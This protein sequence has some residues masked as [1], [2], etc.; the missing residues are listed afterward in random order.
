MWML[1]VVE[2]TTWASISPQLPGPFCPLWNACGKKSMHEL[3]LQQLMW[4]KGKSV[5]VL[6]QLQN[7]TLK[8]CF[9]GKSYGDVLG[10]KKR[11]KNI[12]NS[13]GSQSPLQKSIALCSGKASGKVRGT[14]KDKNY[15]F[16]SW[17]HCSLQLF[18]QR[19]LPLWQWQWD[20]PMLSC[21]EVGACP[22]RYGQQGWTPLPQPPGFLPLFGE[23]KTHSPAL[24]CVPHGLPPCPMLHKDPWPPCPLG[25][26]SCAVQECVGATKSKSSQQRGCQQMVLQPMLPH[27]PVCEGYYWKLSS[28]LE[29]QLAPSV[30]WFGVWSYLHHMI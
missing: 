26:I 16:E 19:C 22:S 30:P 7:Q 3:S 9:T 12:F 27:S 25:A 1:Q 10:K 29:E 28:C 14:Q 18:L 20:S 5:N 21:K 11:Q 15:V 6:W 24:S 8:G 13:P 17:L 2:T 4:G 23:E